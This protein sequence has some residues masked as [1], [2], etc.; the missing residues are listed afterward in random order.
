M[1]SVLQQRLLF[2]LLRITIIAGLVLLL[3]ISLHL[4]L[5]GQ[6]PLLPALSSSRGALL[7]AVLSVV[8]FVL[9]PGYK[10]SSF[11]VSLGVGSGFI[12]LALYPGPLPLRLHEG[13]LLAC[14]GP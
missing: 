13:L 2:P 1:V 11:F 9:L 3:Y 14:G 7:A 10:K 4:L 6:F 8:S 12:I 5:P